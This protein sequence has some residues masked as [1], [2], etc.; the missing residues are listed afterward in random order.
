[1]RNM[2]IHYEG[3][4]LKKQKERR[5]AMAPATMVSNCS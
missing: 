2:K 5:K 1:M 4:L 3:N